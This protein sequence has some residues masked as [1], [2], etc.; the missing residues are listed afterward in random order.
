[1]QLIL[2]ANNIPVSTAHF[3]A[4]LEEFNLCQNYGKHAGVKGL[5]LTDSPGI[6]SQMSGR[7]QLLCVT[8]E[9]KFA[10]VI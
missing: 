8:V 1:M 7:F 3:G 10:Q 5:I 6:R 9:D 2:E 4:V